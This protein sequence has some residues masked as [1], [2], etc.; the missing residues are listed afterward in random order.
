Q[1]DA[2]PAA[3]GHDAAGRAQHVKVPLDVDGEDAIELLVRVLEDRLAH[4]DARRADGDVGAAGAIG[5]VERGVDRRDVADV[6]RTRLGCRAF[7]GRLARDPPGR[8]LVDVETDDAGAVARA[9]DRDRFAD[10]RSGADHQRRL[11]AQIEQTRASHGYLVSP[12]GPMG[13]AA[14]GPPASPASA[15]ATAAA[16]SPNIAG[17][18]TPIGFPAFHS[19]AATTAATPP[20]IAASASSAR[21]RRRYRPATIGT[22]RLTLTS[23]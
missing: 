20:A 13:D 21:G 17:V 8:V 7:G 14:A 19:C 15:N 23:V 22:K 1:D 5:F 3:R 10:A 18:N 16:A 4:V 2:A 9:A 11:P 6:E 12:T